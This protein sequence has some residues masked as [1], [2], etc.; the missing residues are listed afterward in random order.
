MHH[1]S[2][3]GP[4]DPARPE[5]PRLD[6]RL[7]VIPVGGTVVFPTA[8]IPLSLND[9]P[10]VRAVQ[11]ALRGGRLA[12]LL[13]LRPGRLPREGKDAPAVSPFYDVGTLA[14]I[15]QVLQAADG[16]LRALVQGLTR[17]DV[18][19]THRDD[20]IWSAVASARAEIPALGGSAALL[21]TAVV[22]ALEELLDL[23]ADEPAGA[24][25]SIA[26]LT[27]LSQLADIGASNVS[28]PAEEKQALLEER[29]V[30]RRLQRVLEA[31]GDEAR[32][33]RL[34]IGGPGW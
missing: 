15:V 12:V 17:V 9:P 5:S 24:R 25:E 22:R 19:E 11:A 13:S 16:S 30:A 14:R 20:D 27:D 1:P 18:A 10:L 34:G 3:A 2:M 29:Q 28:I 31:L 26:R 7:P 8:L 33:R 6:D 23:A 32:M 21:R 4:G